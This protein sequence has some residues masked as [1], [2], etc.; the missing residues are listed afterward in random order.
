MV[1][2]NLPDTQR[3]CTKM[4]QLSANTVQPYCLDN[5]LKEGGDQIIG[6]RRIP[7]NVR[8]ISAKNIY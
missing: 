5:H 4:V 8:A 3:K 2:P 7:L 6:L 1:R